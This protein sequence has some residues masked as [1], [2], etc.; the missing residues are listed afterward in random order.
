M[1]EQGNTSPQRALAVSPAGMGHPPHGPHTA[2]RR[3]QG[4]GECFQTLS[5]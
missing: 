1:P 4:K 2:P 5:P 3:A